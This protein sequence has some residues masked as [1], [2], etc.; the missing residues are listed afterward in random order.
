[1]PLA[2]ADCL[3]LAERG[4][5]RH[6]L[7]RALLL[8]HMAEPGTAWADQPLG[9]RD[10]CLIGLRCEWFGPWFDAVLA[11]KA[12]TQLLTLRLDLRRFVPVHAEADTPVEVAG[13]LFRR[14]TTRDLAAIAGRIG[15][16]DTNDVDDATEHLCRRLALDPWPADGAAPAR[17]AIDAA[18]DAADP[19]ADLLLEL[20]CE[21][22]GQVQRAPLDIAST[23]WDEV[24][25]EAARVIDDVHLLAGA[26]GWS[27]DQ[28]LAMTPARRALYKQRVLA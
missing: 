14:P 15:G 8:A 27:E 2:D 5:T 23:L 20:A 1:M 10:A 24:S 9:A 4:A 21:H 3:L 26:Y 17:D 13:L 25:A 7:D 16:A 19:L 6:P 22:C 11:C 28:V 18:L 12:C